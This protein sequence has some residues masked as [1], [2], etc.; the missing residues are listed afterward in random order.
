MSA[1][2]HEPELRY[3][4]A[5]ARVEEIL[6][7]MDQVDFDVDELAPLVEEAATLLTYCRGLLEATTLRVDGALARL[8]GDATLESE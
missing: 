3:R 5:V 2:S 4:D 8:T 6:R 7:Q 1:E